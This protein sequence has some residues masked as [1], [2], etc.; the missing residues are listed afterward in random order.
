MLD[1]SALG[2]HIP[3]SHLSSCCLYVNNI[4]STI[5]EWGMMGAFPHLNIRLSIII[6]ALF[7][8]GF[9]SATGIIPGCTKHTQHFV[10]WRRNTGGNT[11][12]QPLA[13]EQ[14]SISLPFSSTSKLL[15]HNPI[16]AGY[17]PHIVPC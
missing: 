15:F 14:A 11:I 1:S 16:D 7:G 6:R 9:S 12:S 10:V 5:M 17:S 8:G 4:I 2:L 3:Y 13:H